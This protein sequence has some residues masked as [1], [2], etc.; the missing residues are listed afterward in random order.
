MVLAG[1]RSQR[2]TGLAPG[3]CGWELLLQ[4]IRNYIIM[5]Y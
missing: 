2:H 5:W 1:G 3:C 4:I